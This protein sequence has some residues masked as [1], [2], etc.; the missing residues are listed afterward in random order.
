MQY[1]LH[2]KLRINTLR[3]TPFG[4]ALTTCFSPFR[5]EKLHLPKPEFSSELSFL[6]DLFQRGEVKQF[7]ILIIQVDKAFLFEGLEKFHSA[8][9][10]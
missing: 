5:D 1:C 6:T 9:G 3:L 4:M 2:A 8:L 10:R 7:Y